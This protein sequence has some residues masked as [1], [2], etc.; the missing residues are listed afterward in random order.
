MSGAED[1]PI[2]SDAAAKTQQPNE[3]RRS[4]KYVVLAAGVVIALSKVRNVMKHQSIKTAID[5][6]QVATCLLYTS[7]AADE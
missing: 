7:D 6:A 1:S 5:F 2:L 4:M 3:L